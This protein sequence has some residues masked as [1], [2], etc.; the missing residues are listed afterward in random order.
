MNARR[1][2]LPEEAVA[3]LLEDYLGDGFGDLTGDAPKVA[4]AFGA[5]DAGEPISP[6]MLG[7]LVRGSG[8]VDAVADCIRVHRERRRRLER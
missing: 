5:F 4:A 7:Q 2:D 3:V 8:G 6:R 1:C